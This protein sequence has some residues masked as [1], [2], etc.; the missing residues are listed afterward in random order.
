MAMS[1]P[2][3]F[4]F[5]LTRLDPVIELALLAFFLTPARSKSPLGF[6]YGDHVAPMDQAVSMLTTLGGHFFLP[7]LTTSRNSTR[8]ARFPYSPS[9][10][11]ADSLYRYPPNGAGKTIPSISTYHRRRGGCFFPTEILLFH[12]RI[13]ASWH[14]GQ[15]HG[16]SFG[17]AGMEDSAS[18][19]KSN[20]FFRLLHP[21]AIASS[22][23][24]RSTRMASQRHCRQQESAPRG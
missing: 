13:A 14:L 6:T 10:S 21:L 7:F 24:S 3:S 11:L 23:R 19:Q 4:L 5:L 22:A 8:R 12:F 16:L 1:S 17:Q 18:L 15:S 9:N 20:S 2:W